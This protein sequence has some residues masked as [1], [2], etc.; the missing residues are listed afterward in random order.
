[1]LCRT[2][3]V[4]AVIAALEG[5]GLI[6]YALLDVVVALREGLSGPSAVSN[7]PGFVLQVLIFMILGAG[8][9]AIARGWWLRSRSARSPFVLAQLL[10]LVVGI[11]IIG[12]GGFAGLVGIALV[13]L[14]VTGVAM[15]FS[16]SARAALDET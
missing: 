6:G 3:Q 9:L 11:P 2:C 1:M 15:V 12:T 4:A 16:A 10:A 14:S 5:V 8:M 13:V 7:L